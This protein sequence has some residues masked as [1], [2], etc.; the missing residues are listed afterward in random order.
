MAYVPKQ[1][2]VP[3]NKTAALQIRNMQRA[4]RH[5]QQIVDL[6]RGYTMAAV[7]KLAV[8]GGLVNEKLPKIKVLN[9]DGV[10]VEVDQEIPASVMLKALE[11]LIERGYGKAPQA[12]LIGNERAL[13][14]DGKALT[15]EEKIAAIKASREAQGQTTD[16]EASEITEVETAAP[17]RQAAPINITPAPE[18]VEIEPIAAQRAADYQ[19]RCEAA[20]QPDASD[21]I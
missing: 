4:G 10:V 13:G 8:L 7:K 9:K 20:E 1:L 17:D 14:A 6:A 3:S 11:L 5:P 21:L 15:I 19:K 18:G 2:A 16:L 12:I